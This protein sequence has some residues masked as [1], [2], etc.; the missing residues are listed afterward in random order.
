MKYF[1]PEVL[2]LPRLGDLWP[3]LLEKKDVFKI[4]MPGKLVA[5][6]V[7]KSFEHAEEMVANVSCLC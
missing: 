3:S 4:A 1:T 5:M 6:S 7:G 2:S